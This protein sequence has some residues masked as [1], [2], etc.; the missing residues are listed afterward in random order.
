MPLW[1]LQ[2]VGSERLEFLYENRDTGKTVRLAPGV[3]YCFRAFYTMITDMVEG[4]WSQF[5]QRLNPDLL[6]QVV[7]LRIVSL[8]VPSRLPHSA[9]FP[10]EGAAGEPLL[11][12]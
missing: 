10:A 12:L 2:T 5:V 1:K 11:L 8:R 7:D 6:G 4:A 9:P 3:A